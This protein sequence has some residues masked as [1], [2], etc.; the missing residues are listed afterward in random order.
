MIPEHLD[1]ALGPEALEDLLCR[2]PEMRAASA[3]CWLRDLPQPTD[4]DSDGSPAMLPTHAPAKAVRSSLGIFGWNRKPVSKSGHE[5]L[6][7]F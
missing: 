2:P 1:R 4:L 7:R 5:N 6:I 3:L